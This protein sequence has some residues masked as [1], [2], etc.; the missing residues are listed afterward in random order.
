MLLQR[1]INDLTITVQPSSTT[2]N[3][4]QL[5]FLNHTLHTGKDEPI[6]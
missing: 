2:V 6:P 5:E 3:L 4:S 1:L